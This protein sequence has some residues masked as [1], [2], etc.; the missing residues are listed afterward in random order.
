MPAESFDIFLG[1]IL[2]LKVSIFLVSKIIV[3]DKPTTVGWGLDTMVAA[4]PMSSCERIF[5]GVIMVF[6]RTSFVD[7]SQYPSDIPANPAQVPSLFL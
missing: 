5:L 1:P 3:P 4:R 7:D 2:V 6:L